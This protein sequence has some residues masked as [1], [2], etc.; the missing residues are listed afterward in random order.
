MK[1]V[2]DVLDTGTCY[3]LFDSLIKNL[4][5]LFLWAP[6]KNANNFFAGL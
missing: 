1:L 3:A 4:F 2:R 5:F 6:K